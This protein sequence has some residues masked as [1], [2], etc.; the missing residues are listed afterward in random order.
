MGLPKNFLKLLRMIG[1]EDELADIV[2]QAGDEGLVGRR[3][4]GLLQFAQAPGQ[5]TGDPTVGP[6]LLHMEVLQLNLV[7]LR[8]NLERKHQRLQGLDAQKHRR[9]GWMRNGMAD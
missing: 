9:L 3:A 2:Q 4:T 8:E 7:E 1:G 6:E 5:H